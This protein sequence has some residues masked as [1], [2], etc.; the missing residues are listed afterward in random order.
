MSKKM[1]T[2]IHICIIVTIIVAIIFVALI[3]VLKYGENGETNMPFEIS[4]I[5]IV[6]TI[7][8]EDVEDTE[9]RW[10]VLVNQSND[11][12]ID[13]KKNENY[14]KDRIIKN[15]IIK[16]FKIDKAPNKG[17]IT[18]YKPSTNE[19]KTF[20]TKDEFR[21]S[22]ITYEGDQKNDIQNLKIS[23]QGG[24]IA[25]R[26]AN[27]KLGS[28]VSNEEDELNYSNLLQKLGLTDNDLSSKITYNMEIILTNGKRFNTSIETWIPVEGIVSQGRTSK[29]IENID[30]VYKRIEN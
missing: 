30:L 28:Y 29:E 10:N 18:V 6:S 20:E 21:V 7:D 27:N 2:I 8:G 26:L 14:A 16:D 4:K 15:I 12:Y 24:R 13:I 22:E 17:E 23:N 19:V 11:I 1:K 25:F 9:N 5:T 3:F